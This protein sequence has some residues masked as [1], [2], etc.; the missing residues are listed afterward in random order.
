MQDLDLVNANGRRAWWGMVQHLDCIPPL[1]GPLW[2]RTGATCDLSRSDWSG[3]GETAGSHNS[4]GSSHSSCP[5]HVLARLCFL[6]KNH[7][8]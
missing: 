8:V 1:I 3:G 6:G 5:C 7:A 4:A 2:P